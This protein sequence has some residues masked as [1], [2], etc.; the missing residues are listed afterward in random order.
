MD[1]LFHTAS[2]FQL[3]GIDPRTSDWL[4]LLGFPASDN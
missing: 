1:F 4:D 3:A 2:P